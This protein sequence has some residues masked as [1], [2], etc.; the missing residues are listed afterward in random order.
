MI[1]WLVEAWG[2]EPARLADLPTL[3]RLFERCVQEVQ[4]KPVQPALWHS[5]PGPGG[6]TGMLLLAES[7]LTIHTFPEHGLATLNLY[8]CLPRPRWPFEERLAEILRAARVGVRELE[9]GQR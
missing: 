4:L 5:F 6:I 1:E 3:Q 9:R 7:H 8:C 2:C